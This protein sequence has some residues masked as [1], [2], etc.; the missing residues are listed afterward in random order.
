[1]H[2]LSLRA[3]CTGNG[4]AAREAEE[5]LLHAVLWVPQ[6]ATWPEVRQAAYRLRW[7]PA[8]YGGL[9]HT[10]VSLHLKQDMQAALF[11]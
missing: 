7:M 8:V 10:L 1:M 4:W 3:V 5:G 2:L 6:P 9:K 11:S